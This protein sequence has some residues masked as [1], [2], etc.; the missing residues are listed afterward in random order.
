MLPA[1]PGRR[2][3]IVVASQHGIDSASVMPPELLA[4]IVDRSAAVVHLIALGGRLT[5]R[6]ATGAPSTRFDGYDELVDAL[7]NRSGGR[8]HRVL[9]GMDF[10]DALR[11]AVEDLRTSYLLT[12]VPTGVAADGWH[13]IDVAVKDRDYEVRARAGYWRTGGDPTRR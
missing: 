6:E 2:R 1:D 3:L 5:W 12:Y 9:A 8:F 7:T 4:A 13:E 10:R 11:D